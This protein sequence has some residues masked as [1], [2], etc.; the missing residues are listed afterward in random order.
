MIT[1]I[2]KLLALGVCIAFSSLFT[3]VSAENL[4]IDYADGGI[5]LATTQIDSLGSASVTSLV[6][7]AGKQLTDQI[8]VKAEYSTPLSKGKKT[9]AGYDW[10]IAV[11]SLSGFG[12]YTYEINE[13][14]SVMG[15]AG[16]SLL[17]VELSSSFGSA[18][19]STLGL[20]YGF[21]GSFEIQDNLAISGEYLYLGTTDSSETS[22]LAFKAVYTF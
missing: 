10:E 3:P 22:A 19:D 18:S 8:S 5:M 15:K 17:S 4:P 1:Q 13:Q 14:L 7:G 6:F 9:W 12:V 2:K 21:G 11:V 16:L 20:S